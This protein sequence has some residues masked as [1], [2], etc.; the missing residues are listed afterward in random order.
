M[1][2]NKK[3]QVRAIYAQNHTLPR[4]ELIELVMK[5]LKTSENSARTHISNA[6]KELNQ[7]LGKQFVTRNTSKPTLKKEKAK[8]IILNNYA[9]LTRKELADKLVKELELKSHNSAQTHISRIA[10]ELGVKLQ[11]M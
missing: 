4:M 6:S 9:T 3:D 10:K 7:S 1:K 8:V 5:E 2:L 11:A